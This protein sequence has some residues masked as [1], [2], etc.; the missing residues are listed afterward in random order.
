[1]RDLARLQLSLRTIAPLVARRLSDADGATPPR[2]QE[3]VAATNVVD[4]VLLLERHTPGDPALRTKLDTPPREPYLEPGDW[5][6]LTDG[7]W[8]TV[9][10]DD[11]RRRPTPSTRWPT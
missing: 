1:M 3:S 7:E 4:G 5:E 2:R 9:T 10:P 11:D 6:P 8:A